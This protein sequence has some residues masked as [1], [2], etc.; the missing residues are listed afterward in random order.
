VRLTF[1]VSDGLYFGEGPFEVMAEDPAAGPLI[2]QGVKLLE[3]INQV[4]EDKT[5]R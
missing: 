3:A 2:Q 4:A 5:K 1:I